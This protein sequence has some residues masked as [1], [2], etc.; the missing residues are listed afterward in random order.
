M[1]NEKAVF[2]KLKLSKH[3]IFSEDSEFMYN[4]RTLI[5]EISDDI[6]NKEWHNESLIQTCD[7]R[8]FILQNNYIIN[9]ANC[10]IKINQ[11]SFS[12]NKTKFIEKL[13]HPVRRLNQIYETKI[14]FDNIVLKTLMK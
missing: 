3:C 14:I 12:N 5:Q 7:E 13:V 1:Y 9:F 10:K 8:N 6:N 11:E 4:N 2:K